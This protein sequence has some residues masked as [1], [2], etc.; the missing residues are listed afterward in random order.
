[1]AGGAAVGVVVWYAALRFSG[2]VTMIA[3]VMK[4]RIRLLNPSPWTNRNIVCREN[5]N[6]NFWIVAGIL[7]LMMWQVITHFAVRVLQ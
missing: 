3:I 5:S 7:R 4:K 2:R 1:M 6:H